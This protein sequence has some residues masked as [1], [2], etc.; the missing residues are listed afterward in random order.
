MKKN[1]SNDSAR[2][3]SLLT[4]G[5]L[6]ILAVLFVALIVLSNNLLR[7][8]RLDLTENR[9]YTL[10]KGT[11][12]VLR[13]LEE[14]IKLSFFYSD[15]AAAD[16]PALRTFAT[17]V[18]EMLEEMAAKSG[19]KISL[20][21]IDPLPFSEE[22]D[23]AAGFGLQAV[24]VG[25][26]GETVYC[27]LAGTNSTDGQTVLPFLQ[28][29]KE[30]FLEYEVAKLV[31][32]LA[33][34]TKPVVG[35]IS[36]LTLAPGFDPATRQRRPGWAVYGSLR[37]QFELRALD[38]ATTSVIDP[39]IQTVVLVHPKAISD[40]LAYALDQFVLRGGK[41]ALFLD[42]NAEQDTAGADPNNPAAAMMADKSSDIPKLLK[43]WGVEYDPA[44]V[45]LD[46]QYALSVQLG[47]G[48]S[49]RHLAILGFTRE[50]MNQQDV[51]SSQLSSVNLQTAGAFKLAQSSTLT[52][53]PLVQSSTQAGLAAMEQVKFMPDPSALFQ[54]FAPT[55]ETYVVAG[56]LSGKLKTAFPDKAGD[57]HLAESTDDANLLIVA[58]TDLL[59]DRLWVRTQQFFGQQI[60]NPFANNGDFAVN[61]VD[62]LTGSSAL[63]SVR[64]RATSS[65]PFTRVEDLRRSADDRYR[66]T[67]RK[68]NEELQETESKLNELQRGKSKDQAQ[69]LSPEQKA[70]L[71]RFQ[72]EKLRIRKE[73][74]SVR[75]QLDADIESL[76]TLLKFLNIALLP[77]GLTLAVAVF[78]RWRQR[79]R[80]N[81]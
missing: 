46:S 73:L 76:G 15:K 8:A 79:R 54:V 31:H 47:N 74:R 49:L 4:G 68:L 20:S 41:L 19:G 77:I 63:I 28:P 13:E 62:N 34:P 22:E 32:G 37:E 23:R 33:K 2:N 5:T 17:R 48:Q 26:S 43:A 11:R 30:A 61:A 7:G 1:H 10:S 36:S 60:L 69:I 14:P 39:A 45:L 35:L 24:P 12:E 6:A 38:P 70:E 58:D 72:S 51:I 29:D 78:A 67:E 75:R 53:T 9:L 27:G 57:K 52:L 71:Q 64:G 44:K 50:A 81:A 21:I 40:E 16:I 66:S 42:P 25:K 56:R 80:V 3:R 18:R 65:R 55:G 59:S